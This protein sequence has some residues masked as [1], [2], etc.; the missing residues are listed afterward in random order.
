MNGQYLMNEFT[1][2][3]Q[4]RETCEWTICKPRLRLTEAYRLYSS[5]Q[6]IANKYI[7]C[8]FHPVKCNCNS[9]VLPLKPVTHDPVCD[10][11]NIM[12][13]RRLFILAVL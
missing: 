10:V 8:I 13:S 3:V 5:F 7:S 4:P 6:F 9:L 12:P 1:L 11:I 2:E